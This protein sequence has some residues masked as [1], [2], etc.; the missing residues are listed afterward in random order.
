MKPKILIVDDEKDFIQL[1]SFSLQKNNY[2]VQ[3]ATNGGE[4]IRIVKEWIPDLI[5]LDLKMPQMD[6]EHFLGEL[7]N[8]DSRI[9]VIVISNYIDDLKSQKQLQSM[10]VKAFLNKKEPPQALLKL[11][12]AHLPKGA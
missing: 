4:G 2:Q 8:A 6:G 5:L 10:G 11:I 1:V 12:T 7:Q 9:P 3:S